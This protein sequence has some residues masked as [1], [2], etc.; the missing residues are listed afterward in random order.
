MENNIEVWTFS[1]NRRGRHIGI[2]SGSLLFHYPSMVKYDF[3]VEFSAK[4]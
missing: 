2:D 3:C 1:H 4:C